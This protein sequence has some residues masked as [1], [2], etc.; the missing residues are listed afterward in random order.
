MTKECLRDL[1]FLTLKSLRNLDCRQVSCVLQVC[2]VSWDCID[3][4]YGPF[5]IMIRRVLRQWLQVGQTNKTELN[6]VYFVYEYVSTLIA[7][8]NLDVTVYYM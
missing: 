5:Y 6:S 2:E 8:L 3:Y 4:S 1:D 7:Q